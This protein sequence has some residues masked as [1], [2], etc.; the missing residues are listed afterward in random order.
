MRSYRIKIA[1]LS[2][3]FIDELY[4][5]IEYSN[6]ENQNLENEENTSRI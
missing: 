2:N 1:V 4:F 6:A 5:I 3:M